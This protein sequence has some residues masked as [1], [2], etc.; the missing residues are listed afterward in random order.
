M[1]ASGQTP[2]R[3]SRHLQDFSKLFIQTPS[4]RATV[5]LCA[6][7][8]LGYDGEGAGNEKEYF[9]FEKERDR[10]C[11]VKFRGLGT[12]KMCV[13]VMKSFLRVHPV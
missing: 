12:K 13:R 1:Q 7:F 8:A 6:E 4:H 9:L 10:V 11:C 5:Q 2:F 3:M